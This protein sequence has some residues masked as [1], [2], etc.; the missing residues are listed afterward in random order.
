M[1]DQEMHWET[2]TYG[3]TTRITHM[4][5]IHKLQLIHYHITLFF[6]KKNVYACTE[7]VCTLLFI[8]YHITLFL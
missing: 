8:H 4:F 6:E 1:C 5:F 3:F 7:N 2:K